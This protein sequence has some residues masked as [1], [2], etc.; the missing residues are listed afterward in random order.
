MF[1]QQIL[2]PK[3][4]NCNCFAGPQRLCCAWQQH[5]SFVNTLSQLSQLALGFLRLAL[6]NLHRPMQASVRNMRSR[7]LAELGLLHLRVGGW[8]ACKLDVFSSPPALITV[9]CSGRCGRFH[10]H[11]RRLLPRP[12]ICNQYHLVA[13]AVHTKHAQR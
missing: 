7:T 11:C 8:P 13:H 5:C 12:G 3:P 6:R 1:G 2:R 9:S 10:Q 4:P